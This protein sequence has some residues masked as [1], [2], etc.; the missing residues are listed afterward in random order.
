MV[1]MDGFDHLLSWKLKRGSH[2][3]PGKDGGTC[4][5]E[6]ALVAAGFQYRPIRSAYDMPEC[7][8][9][10]ICCLAMLLNDVAS[11][12]DR[13]RLLP[14]VTRLACADTPEVEKAR[15]AYIFRHLGLYYVRIHLCGVV[16]LSFDR[17]LKVLEGALAIGRQADPLGPDEVLTRMDA[18]RTAQRKPAK[19]T[20]AAKPLLSKVKS[21]LTMKETDPVA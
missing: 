5:N 19:V 9:R 17:G 8:S 3:F 18:A 21:W 4:I 16:A 15:A 14:Y 20:T 12:E 10:P 1:T 13:Q 2:H 11:D 7:F 6:A